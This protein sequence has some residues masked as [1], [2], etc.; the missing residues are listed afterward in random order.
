M[1]VTC[2]YTYDQLLHYT[3]AEN[4]GWYQWFSRHPAALDVP[5]PN[6]SLASGFTDQWGHDI[7]LSELEM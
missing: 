4:G 5:F 6:E 1:P 2:A 3:G 7:L